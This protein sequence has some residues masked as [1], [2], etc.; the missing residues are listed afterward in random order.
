MLLRSESG[1]SA[2]HFGQ[3]ANRACETHQRR[4][5][6]NEVDADHDSHEI[7]A[8]RRPGGQKVDTE[9]EGNE[10]GEDRPSP[11][12][13]LDDACP[14]SA[15]QP[16]NNEERCEHHGHS[17][18]A[19]VGMANQEIPSNSTDDRVQQVQEKPMPA[20]GIERV[21]Q[22]HHSADHEHPTERQDR[23]SGCG[24]GLAN[25]DYAE[26]RQKNPEG[27]KPSSG[28][29]DLFQAGSENITKCGHCLFS[30]ECAAGTPAT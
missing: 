25:A 4:A 10:P 29:P 11:P 1:S 23:E 15:E 30:F 2:L 22:P 5:V 27:K 9:T 12:G 7:V 3:A 8:R 13:K 6:K 17:L 26:N 24:L 16:P 18:R 28:L 20:E 14:D 21:D 19:R